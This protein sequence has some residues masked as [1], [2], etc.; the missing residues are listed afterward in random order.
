MTSKKISK[1]IDIKEKQKEELERQLKV[2]RGV[3]RQNKEE[4]KG[5]KSELGTLKD[6]V[7]NEVFSSNIELYFQYLHILGKKIDK[8]EKEVEK[9]KEEVSKKEEQLLTSYR[10][11]K[12]LNILKDEIIKDELKKTILNEQKNFDFDYLTRKFKK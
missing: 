4:L 1:L 7:T 12:A 9:K 5:L 2:E 3:L 6:A 11:T 8:K 10:E